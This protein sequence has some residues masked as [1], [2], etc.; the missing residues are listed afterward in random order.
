MSNPKEGK[1]Y[2]YIG[3]KPIRLFHVDTFSSAPIHLCGNHG[4]AFIVRKIDNSKY[5]FWSCKNEFYA[6][7]Y[8]GQLKITVGKRWDEL[9]ILEEE[10]YAEPPENQLSIHH[11]SDIL[12]DTLQSTDCETIV[13][14]LKLCIDTLRREGY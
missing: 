8:A 9:F 7:E 13:N 1:R 12:E 6:T 4:D 5:D 11:V 10:Y 3:E 14:N 2:V